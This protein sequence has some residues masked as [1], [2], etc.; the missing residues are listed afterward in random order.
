MNEFAEEHMPALSLY[1]SDDSEIAH[2]SF[3]DVLDS[4]NVGII[5]RGIRRYLFSRNPER[6]IKMHEALGIPIVRK[7]VMGTVGRIVPAY[8]GFNY[9][10]NG[11]RDSKL[12]SVAGF[13]VGGSVF[14]EV[15]HTYAAAAGAKT[16]AS[17]FL[18]GNFHLDYRV[19]MLAGNLALVALQR[20]NRARTT[21]VMDN[22]L[23]RGREFSPFYKNWLGIDN[24]AL[25][26]IEPQ[27]SLVE[28]LAEYVDYSQE[29]YLMPLP[30]TSHLELVEEI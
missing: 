16:L 3:N 9:R 2:T 19:G 13:A 23:Q 12:D 25:E 22:A 20:Y 15:V 10:L 11:R 17:E 1:E 30:E 14:N 8:S 7:V 5:R 6:S 28:P 24:R 18:E 21:K 27:L 29:P 4:K 26:S